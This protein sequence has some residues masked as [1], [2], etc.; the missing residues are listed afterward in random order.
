[1]VVGSALLSTIVSIIA[2]VFTTVLTYRAPY[3][4]TLKSY[5]CRWNG[6]YITEGEF[7]PEDFGSLCHQTVSLLPA[8]PHSHPLTST[9]RFAYYT[10][11]PVLVIQFA[12]L[13][14]GIFALFSRQP[15]HRRHHDLEKSQGHQLRNVSHGRRSY[16]TK[17]ERSYQDS[18][19]ILANAK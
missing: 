13:G 17:S 3:K 1:M 8:A 9:K 4:D 5:T 2:I 14:L 6:R 12:L 16:D 15:S 11:I 7:V 19:R 10:T 18:A